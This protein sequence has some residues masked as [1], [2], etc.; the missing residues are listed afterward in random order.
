MTIGHSKSRNK[1]NM[2]RIEHNRLHEYQGIYRVQYEDK[3]DLDKN[4]NP[5]IKFNYF[6]L[7]TDKQITNE[8]DLERIK[9]LGIPPS[10]V[11]VWIS[12][13]PKS[14]I[15][16]IGYDD[17]DRKQYRYHADHIKKATEEKFVRLYKFIN[18]IP[19]LEETI[20][21]HINL[22][23][24]TKENT[25]AIMLILVKELHF[26][27]GKE[28]YAR[29]NKSYGISSMLKSH[30]K[31]DGDTIKFKFKAKSNKIVSYTYKNKL[32]ADELTELMKLP[33]D[34]LFQYKNT[35]GNILHVSDTDLNDYIR[36]YMGIEF[37][38]KD[39]RTYAANYLFTKNLLKETQKRSPKNQKVIK[40]NIRNASISTAIA[41]RHT[42]AISKKSY[43]MMLLR[44]IYESDPEYFVRNKTKDPTKV[45]VSILKEFK[46]K[47]KEKNKEN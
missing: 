31:I 47:L 36:E 28:I 42:P 13:D 24:Y 38:I 2:K 1:K 9:K 10:Y 14:K 19:I 35:L 15:Q 18:A 33:G 22:D 27:V 44:E 3:K 30:V 29:E 25:I 16:S 34:K 43:V 11:D 4:G 40:E 37:T 26:R 17:R 32:I 12:K 20:E 46:K 5:K 23:N 7:E 39:F 8:T 45:L 6:D 41:L 21:K